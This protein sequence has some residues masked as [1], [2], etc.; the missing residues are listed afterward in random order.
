MSNELQILPL[1]EYTIER[2]YYEDGREVK[3]TEVFT[4]DNYETVVD[5]DGDP[6]SVKFYRTGNLVREYFQLPTK[7]TVTPVD[8]ADIPK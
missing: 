4:A 5:G 8:E 3:D 6:Q 2:Q 7:I 1:R